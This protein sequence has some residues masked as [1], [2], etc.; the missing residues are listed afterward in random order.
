MFYDDFDTMIA[1]PKRNVQVS[2]FLF[3]DTWKKL[4]GAHCAQKEVDTVCGD[5]I[6][7]T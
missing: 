4:K 1:K 7:G 3:R 5:W 2:V 6:G